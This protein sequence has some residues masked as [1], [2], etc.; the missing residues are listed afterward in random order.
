MG[1]LALAIVVLSAL[2][3]APQTPVNPSTPVRRP[4]KG[5][6]GRWD[7]V[8]DP[9]SAVLLTLGSILV[10]GGG[11]KW[12]KTLNG[13][14]AVSRLSE[15]NVT[16]EEIARAGSYGREGL[17]DFFRLLGTDVDA[18]RREAAGRT[19]AALWKR[20]DLIAEEEKALV[21]R[22]YVV[23]WK[24]RR[25]YPR[26]LTVAVPIRVDFG[27][28]FL[29]DEKGEVGPKNLWW[30]YR[31]TGAERASLEDYSPWRQ[32]Q[33]HAVFEINPTD[34]A[35]N[36]PHRLVFQARVR[37]EGLT[38]PWE[39]ELP[40]VPFNFELDPLLAVD[41]LHTLPDESRAVHF[42]E[43]IRLGGVPDNVEPVYMDLTE[44]LVLRD[45]PWFLIRTPL[46]C[47]LAHTVRIEFADVPGQFPAGKIVMSGQTA[48]VVPGLYSTPL[49]L[50][51]NL[52]PGS[53]ER[54]GEVRLRAIL[55]A[56]PQ[57]GWADPDVRSIWPGT[58]VT[59][60]MTARVVRR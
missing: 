56:D 8:A 58:I 47:D 16:A 24:A 3:D 35:T 52:P 27:V 11:R 20:D 49:L 23:D 37:T 2:A 45:P 22:G 54:P 10:I 15:P 57:R 5:Q 59:D 26:A 55:S 48:G 60:W 30:S 14:R 9:R 12:L 7:W 29:R 18:L 33:G 25:R 36:G 34:F 32:G 43:G 13:R 38:D 1:G 31:I 50:E 6:T 44:T 39:I 53:I 51:G 4:A 40:H 42:A 17:L 46:P 21:R 28:P 41:A 19:V